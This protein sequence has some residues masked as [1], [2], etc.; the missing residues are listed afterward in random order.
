MVC[1]NKVTHNV[2]VLLQAGDFIMSSPVLRLGFVLL[3]KIRTKSLALF[4]QPRTAADSELKPIAPTSSPACSNTFVAC[5]FCHTNLMIVSIN[6]S[7]FK[8]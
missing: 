8:P 4:V 3:M 5:S 7:T 2:Q 1:P 6:W